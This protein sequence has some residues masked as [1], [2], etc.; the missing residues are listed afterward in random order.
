MSELEWG[1][2]I[3]GWRLAATLDKQTFAVEEPILVTVVLQN[4][5]TSDQ[6]YDPAGAEADVVLECRRADGQPVTLTAWGNR[7]ATPGGAPRDS[8]VTL[9][10]GQ[11]AL[12]EISATRQLDLTLPGSYQLTVSRGVPPGRENGPRLRSKTCHFEVTE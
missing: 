5:T 3:A 4:V 9:A 7:A 2:A 1:D 11:T 8:G 10:A 6:I 12:G